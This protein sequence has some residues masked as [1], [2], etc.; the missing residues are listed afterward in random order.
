MR[1]LL[2]LAILSLSTVARAE[3]TAKEVPY[4][5]SGCQ[6]PPK[7][8]CWRQ[9]VHPTPAE[10]CGC[11]GK[12][13]GGSLPSVRWRF[14]APCEIEAH[15]ERA[16][17]TG[18]LS[19]VGTG[20]QVPLG[21]FKSCKEL[22]AAKPALLRASCVI[23]GGAATD[24]RVERSGDA[25]VATVGG[26]EAGRHPSPAQ[27][28]VVVK[29]LVEVAPP[30]PRPII[31]R[32]DNLPESRPDGTRTGAR[33]LIV[34]VDGG[35]H[36]VGVFAACMQIFHKNPELTT[37]DCADAARKRHTLALS[38][39]PEKNAIILTD[40]LGDGPARERMRIELPPGREIEGESMHTE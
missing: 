33:K 27:Q 9:A 19:L 20:F 38:P 8:K 39:S 3:C 31:V 6:G 28:T 5:E 16:T 13:F 37:I 4:L 17:A 21:S 15:L 18:A 12:T 26:K 10:W 11:D 2:V 36:D 40:K 22:P 29:P 1:A 7:Q 35:W 30:P 34:N 14:M 32:F 24:V 23:D 25:V